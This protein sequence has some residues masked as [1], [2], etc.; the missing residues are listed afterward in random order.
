[1][2]LAGGGT[3]GIGIR[4]SMLRAELDVDALRGMGTLDDLDGRDVIDADEPWS[5]KPEQGQMC[6]R[7]SQDRRR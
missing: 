1:M 5:L 4:A 6:L 3:K 7:G 2:C